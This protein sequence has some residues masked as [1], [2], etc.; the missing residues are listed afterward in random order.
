MPQIKKPVE[1]QKTGTG[2]SLG[3]A[4]IGV[5]AAAMRHYRQQSR[6]A[7]MRLIIED[8]AAAHPDALQAQPPAA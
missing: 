1:Q 2:I 3:P 6:S 4:E 5:I 8:W 7:A